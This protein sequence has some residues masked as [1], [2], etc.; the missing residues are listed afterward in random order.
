MQPGI[1]GGVV[2][3]VIVVIYVA[4]GW[5]VLRP[6]IATDQVRSN[7]LGVATSLMFFSCAALHHV[8]MAAF[9]FGIAGKNM[10]MPTMW[11]WFAVLLD[12]VVA[13]VGVW[14]WTLRTQYGGFLQGAKLFDD[15]TERRGINELHKLND[16]L[17]AAD[18]MK[19]HLV[20]VASHEL[21][22]PLTSI[23]GFS[24]LLLE[25]WPAL[26]DAQ[27][28]EFIGIIR[29]QSDRLSRVVDDTLTISKL[30][31]GTLIRDLQAVRVRPVIEQTVAELHTDHIEIR[32]PADVT[33][34]ADRDHLHQMVLNYL[35][36]ACKYGQPPYAVAVEPEAETVRIAVIDAG[37]VP[38]EFVDDLYVKFTQ[39]RRHVGKGTG[40]GLSIVKG[41]A[42]DHG[43]Q[44]WYERTPDGSCFNLRLPR[45][46]I[47]AESTRLTTATQ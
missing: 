25:R 24:V 41:L 18:E 7:R 4:I 1:L 45:G 29:E 46:N 20:A 10:N 39:A 3:L 26:D 16:Q 13:L 8:L 5:A 22:T 34:L 35:S 44:A 27:K 2:N 21:R 31:A 19:D 37:D 12:V 38:E 17:L 15:L 42:E 47:D 32:C 33:V 23:T 40:L 6:L 11:P 36:N 9:L 30:A 28:I 14:Y 43:G